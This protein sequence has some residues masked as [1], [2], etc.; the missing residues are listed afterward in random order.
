MYVCVYDMC[1][2]CI[3]VDIGM[4]VCLMFICLCVGYMSRCGICVRHICVLNSY[5]YVFG[6]VLYAILC[7]VFFV[8]DFCVICMCVE[9]YW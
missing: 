7:V 8:C 3:R 6:G 4:C 1:G 5:M 9:T 2:I